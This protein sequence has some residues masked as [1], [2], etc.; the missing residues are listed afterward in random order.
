MTVTADLLA[1]IMT[2]D[3]VEAR[4]GVLELVDGASSAPA[5]EVS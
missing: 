3:R 4:E 2:P 5:A 1:S